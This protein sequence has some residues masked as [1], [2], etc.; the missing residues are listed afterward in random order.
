M[1]CGSRLVKNGRHPSG[2]QR[3]RCRTCGSSTVRHRPDVRER[4]Q[5][6]RFLRWLS[7]KASQAEHGGGTGRTFRH[8][9]A[10][11]WQ[12]QPRMPV[13]G[14]VHDTVL[15]DGIWIGTWCLLIAISDTGHVIAWQWCARESTAAWTALFDQVPAPIVAVTDGGSGIR[16]ALHNTW[17]D[18]AVQ[19]C[20]FHLQLNVT[21]ELTR[22]PRTAAGRALRQISL[23]LSNVHDID[24]AITWQLTL[25]AWWQQYGHLTRERTLYDNGRFGF[26]HDRLRKAWGILHRA[27]RAGHVFTHLT[28]GN[29]RTTSRLEGLNS[30]IRNLLHQHRGMPIEHRKRAAEW[31]LLLHEIPIN[32]AHEHATL[33]APAP[34]PA[35]NE[36]TGQ[37]TLYDTGL[38]ATEGLWLR[39]GWA[40]RS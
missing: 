7:G 27:A 17:P 19:R 13:T 3:W 12:L 38:D 30:Q 11:C 2:T 26:T 25:E 28:H 15:V 32:H 14:E 35:R 4:E 24:A 23:N 33:P 16:A 22:T 39:T 10:W 29:P 34:R 21:G 20:I 8:D 5:L 18:T 31:F 9:T 36:T 1:V 40:G 6:R 37:P